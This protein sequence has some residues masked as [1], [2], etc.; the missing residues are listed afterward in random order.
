MELNITEKK[1]ESLL[2]RTEVK[3]SISFA[4]AIPPKDDIKKEL[5]LQLKADE[6]LIVVKKVFS[7]FKGNNAD[8][9]A[10][11]YIDEGCMKR[12]EGKK[13]K[14]AEAKEG[15]E[16]APEAKEEP[17]PR[18]E[19]KPGEKLKEAPKEEKPKEGR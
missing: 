19:K 18:E 4:G 11:H 8:V 13:Q 15:E 14:K 12:I 1:E 7:K 16:A 2:S 9:L 10:Y 3:A 17:K 6:N 5:A